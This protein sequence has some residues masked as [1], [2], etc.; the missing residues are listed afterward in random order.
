MLSGNGSKYQPKKVTDDIFQHRTPICG[1]R[2]ATTPRC[3]RQQTLTAIAL[4]MRS[5]G[6]NEGS[7]Q[8]RWYGIEHARCGHNSLLRAARRQ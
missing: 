2:P 8:R 4:A 6:R 1:C 3:D 5:C 7:V